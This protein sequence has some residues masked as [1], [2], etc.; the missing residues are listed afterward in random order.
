MGK[1]AR[2]S[3][4]SVTNMIVAHPPP[5]QR[6]RFIC[7]DGAGEKGFTN[8]EFLPGSARMQLD[9]VNRVSGESSG[10]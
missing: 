2:L 6:N 3:G 10:Q 5:F 1:I 8:E 4:G 7:T 9:T